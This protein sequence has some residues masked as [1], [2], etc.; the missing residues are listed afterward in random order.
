MK[1]KDLVEYLN[2]IL[3]IGEIDDRSLN[4]LQ[5]DNSGNVTRVA[6]AVD[7]CQDSFLRAA[8]MK[9][10]FLLVHHGLFWSDPVAITGELYSRIKILIE[11]DIA[12]YAAHLPLDLHPELGNNAQIGEILG[13]PVSGDFGEYHGVVIGR[14]VEFDTLVALS[15]IVDQIREK[16]KCEPEVWGFGPEYIKKMCYVS[17]GGLSLLNQAI[18]RGMDMFFTGEPGHSSYWSA[19]EA[20][21]NVVFGGHYATEI[22]GVKAVGREIEKKFGLEVEFI[23]LPT[24]H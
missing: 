4:G 1:T 13:W 22:L 19:K 6:L 12:L 18:D 15:D 2:K 16:L 8:E 23:D 11:A 21:I 24:G 20:K 3:R 9:A 17:G 5:L 7:A 10:D 14:E